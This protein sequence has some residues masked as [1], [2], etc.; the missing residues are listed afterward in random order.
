M[1]TFLPYASYAESARALDN[2]RLGKQRVECKQI[3]NALLLPDVGW[4]NHPATKMWRGHESALACYAIAIC[5]EWVRR[6]YNDSL[7]PYFM[8]LQ[9]RLGSDTLVR[10]VWLGNFDFHLSHQSNLL[11]KDP[12]YY[13]SEFPG[14]PDNLPYIWPVH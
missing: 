6:G 7:L 11:R 9:S 1:Q 2:R 4:K 12:A 14:V 8:D 10:P 5:R 3:L 13:R